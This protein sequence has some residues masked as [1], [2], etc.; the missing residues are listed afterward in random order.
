MALRAICEFDAGKQGSDG[1]EPSMS[2][3]DLKLRGSEDAGPA[4]ESSASEQVQTSGDEEPEILSCSG[5]HS[6]PK[7]SLN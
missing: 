5:R 2:G 7:G 3:A 1:P 4:S 6:E